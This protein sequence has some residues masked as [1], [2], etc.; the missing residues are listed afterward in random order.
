MV[1]ISI[2]FLISG[3]VLIG[4]FILS[5][6]FTL[7]YKRLKEKINTEY[8]GLFISNERAFES[9]PDKALMY[10]F[11]GFVTSIANILNWASLLALALSLIALIITLCTGTELIE[12]HTME[13]YQL[14][15]N[16]NPTPL[17]DQIIIYAV[18]ESGEPITF[19]APV[20]N[21]AIV[22]DNERY[23]VI[24]R[25]EWSRKSTFWVF[26]YERRREFKTT[27]EVHYTNQ[28]AE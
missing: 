22:D 19:Y 26:Y 27:Y 4:S 25:T 12:K 20:Y 10:A 14:S 17:N 8:G 24:D 18:Q 9:E 6:I 1:S 21:C 3:G 23:V 5:F 16:S 15:E 13:Q 28:Q 11:A 2:V 7:F